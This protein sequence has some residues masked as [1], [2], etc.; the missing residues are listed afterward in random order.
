MVCC[1]LSIATASSPR[2]INSHNSVT[3]VT[4]LWIAR[5][6][7]KPLLPTISSLERH[8]AGVEA[9]GHHNRLVRFVCQKVKFSP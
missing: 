6:L 1:G 3:A 5:V 9:I 7:K 4:R 8:A 2:D